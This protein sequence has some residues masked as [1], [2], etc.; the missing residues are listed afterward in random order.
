[1]GKWRAAGSKVREGA[2]AGGGSE[3]IAILGCCG[4]E[5]RQ[6]NDRG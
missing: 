4:C 1:M 3:V 2:A 6:R 5:K